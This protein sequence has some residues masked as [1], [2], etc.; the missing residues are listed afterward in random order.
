MNPLKLHLGCGTKHIEGYVNIDIRYL[1]NVDEVNNIKFLRN[2][3]KESVDVI[4][5]C[6]VLEHF[7]RWDF[8]NVLKRWYELLKPN[9]ILRLAVP[10][11]ESVVE[12]YNNT[13]DLSAI[14][15]ILY[16]GQDYEEN[17]HHVIFDYNFLFNILKSIGFK[18]IEKYD[19]K[20]T[21]HPHVDDYSKAYIPHKDDTGL[22]MSLNIEAIK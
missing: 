12:Y 13:K 18:F 1:P 2:Y 16:G 6:H 14:M 9:G 15:G 7:S 10:N 21:E 20:L 4:Y 11:F 22:L 8:D 5:A 3:K 19:W 17:H